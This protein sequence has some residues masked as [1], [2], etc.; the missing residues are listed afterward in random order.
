[1]IMN[2]FLQFLSL[3]LISIAITGSCQIRTKKVPL[4]SVP[5]P[6]VETPALLTNA[7]NTN[8]WM[9]KH[10][11]DNFFD[12]T[13]TYST[14]TMLTGG[15]NKIEFNRAFTRYAANLSELPVKDLLEAQRLLMERAVESKK[16]RSE[17]LIYERLIQ[18]NQHFFYN[19]NS[20][21]RNEEAYI[22]VLEVLLESPFEDSLSKAQY[23]FQLER[24]KLN[25]LGQI[26]N[27]FTYS[28]REGLIADL[29]SISAKYTLILFSN[30]DCQSCAEIIANFSQS[31]RVNLLLENNILKIINIYIDEDLAT[32]F[33]KAPEY[34]DNWINAYDPEGLLRSNQLYNV[35]ALPSLYLLDV[36]KVVIHKDA[37]PETVFDFLIQQSYR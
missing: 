28:T 4:Q 25:R 14:D 20:P 17:E 13:R 9:V 3:F 37:D 23:Q 2:K 22:P 35:R 33:K 21:Y 36:D 12:S 6:Y 29:Y 5:F 16:I 7:S 8:K 24:C 10:Y 34:P 18:F 19:P 31:D 1:M 11:W 27:N 32:W 30:P 26:A 15:V